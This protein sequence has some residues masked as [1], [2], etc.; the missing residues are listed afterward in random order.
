MVEPLSGNY[1]E[2]LVARCY[3]PQAVLV[4]RM[5]AYTKNWIMDIMYLT[6]LY[7]CGEGQTGG[8]RWQGTFSLPVS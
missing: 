7:S 5:A 6:Q 1:T 2:Q 4:Q 3:V 8:G